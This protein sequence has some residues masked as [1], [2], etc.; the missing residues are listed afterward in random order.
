[1]ER[2]EDV[3]Y[4]DEYHHIVARDHGMAICVQALL[5]NHILTDMCDTTIEVEQLFIGQRWSEV[6]NHNVVDIVE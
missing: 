3:K 5:A 2:E 6:L 4:R 1:M